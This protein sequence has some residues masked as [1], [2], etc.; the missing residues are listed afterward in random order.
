[1]KWL[2]LIEFTN[3]NVHDNLVWNNVKIDEIRNTTKY[4]EILNNSGIS[5]SLRPF[6]WPRLCGATL[7]RQNSSFQYNEILKKC[8]NDLLQQTINLQIDKDLL[9][10][11]PNNFCFSKFDSNGIQ[12]L[13]RILQSIAYTYPELGY[14]QV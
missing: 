7:K 10:T 1:M 3:E 14:C 9:R 4:W 8:T 11:L 12:A 6:L 2:S 5:H 13:R